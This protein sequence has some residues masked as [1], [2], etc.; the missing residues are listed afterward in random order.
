LEGMIFLVIL[1]VAS[2]LRGSAR[3]KGR[4]PAPPM[5]PKR[6]TLEAGPQQTSGPAPASRPGRRNIF[7]ETIY[8]F[9]KKRVERDPDPVQRQEP[10]ETKRRDPAATKEEPKA[11][12]VCVQEGRG[13]GLFQDRDELARG[14]I[15]AEVLGPPLSKRKKRGFIQ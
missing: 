4:Q 1:V 13:L 14:I 10:V 3:Q 9:P 12:P 5:R 11:A 8:M 2:L 6:P 15:L 7:D